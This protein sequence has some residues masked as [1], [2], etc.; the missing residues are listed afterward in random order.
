MKRT[1]GIILG[2]YIAIQAAPQFVEQGLSVTKSIKAIVPIYYLE[3]AK[4]LMGNEASFASTA[5]AATSSVASVTGHVQSSEDYALYLQARTEEAL[6]SLYKS[7]SIRV[8]RALIETANAYRMDP[9][10]L[11]AVIK[12]ESRFN[13]EIIGSHGEIGLMQIKPSTAKWIAEKS[14]RFMS[15]AQVRAM[16]F[17]PA[18]NIRFGAAYLNYLR[19][20]FK[21]R[22]GRY[23]EAYNMG[24]ENMMTK[25]RGG[26]TPRAYT[27]NIMIHYREITFASQSY[28]SLSN[29]RPLAYR[30]QTFDL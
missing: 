15:E 29:S 18:E 11:M 27:K 22:S 12:Q 10:F 30:G 5:S 24:A 17:D 3:H 21:G 28:W 20:R 4:E 14:G 1:I 25:I 19:T 7:H 13:P 2:S 6:P 9:A 16:L 23:I 8:T 26:A